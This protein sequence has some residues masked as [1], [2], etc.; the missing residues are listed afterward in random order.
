MRGRLR[1]GATGRLGNRHGRRAPATCY[2]TRECCDADVSTESSG[3]FI[4][5]PD[6]AQPDREPDDDDCPPVSTSEPIRG[7]AVAG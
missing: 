5:N 2:S 6:C 4:T 1:R 7:D 3:N